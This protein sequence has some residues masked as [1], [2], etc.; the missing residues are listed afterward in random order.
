MSENEPQEPQEGSGTSRE[1]LIMEIPASSPAEDKANSDEEG[2]DDGE[3]DEEEPEAWWEG[4]EMGE[5]DNPEQKNLGENADENSLNVKSEGL[6][7]DTKSTL[8][9]SIFV[10][11]DL[12]R[13]V[14]LNFK[15]TVVFDKF[16]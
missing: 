15:P 4:T 13:Y 7:E 11:Y 10:S 16:D 6:V 9:V 14:L 12:L 8:P 5:D 2:E 3:E 1:E